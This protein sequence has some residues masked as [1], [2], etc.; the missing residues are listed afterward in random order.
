LGWLVPDK[1][2]EMMLRKLA[3]QF[4]RSLCNNDKGKKG[5]Q[6]DT[7]VLRR[8]LLKLKGERFRLDCGHHIT[9]SVSNRRSGW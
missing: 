6:D 7:E 3:Y 5:L 8:A 1:M 4:C 9:L 2:G